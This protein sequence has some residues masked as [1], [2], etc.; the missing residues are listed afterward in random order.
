MNSWIRYS[1]PVA[2]VFGSAVAGHGVVYLNVEQAQRAIFPSGSFTAAPV[3]LT[4]EQKKAI[5]AA[6]GIRQRSND[7][8]AWRVSGGGWFIVDEVLGKHEYI[9]FAIGLTE[10]GAVK[11]VEIMEY[12]ETYGGEVREAKWRAQFT[13]K[14]KAAPLKLDEDIKNISGATLS[15][16]HMAE[17]VRRLLAVHAIALR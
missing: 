6:S 14:T 9:T 13:G 12:R 4:A 17:G 16:R 7:V 2:A 5:E 1:L 15:S 10:G 3:K 11:G 8:K